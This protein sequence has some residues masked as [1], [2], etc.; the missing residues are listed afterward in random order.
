MQLNSLIAIYTSHSVVPAIDSLFSYVGQGPETGGQGGTVTDLHPNLRNEPE[1]NRTA[2]KAEK[3]VESVTTRVQISIQS[4]L[5]GWRFPT[6]LQTAQPGET[7]NPGHGLDPGQGRNVDLVAVVSRTTGMTV[8]LHEV[9][10]SCCSFVMCLT[11]V[12][13]AD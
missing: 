10:I 11:E 7:L 9:E 3:R 12:C 8:V 1:R 6:T 5:T 2:K 4:R 13:Y